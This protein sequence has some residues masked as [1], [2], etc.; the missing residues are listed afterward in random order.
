MKKESF[1]LGDEDISMPIESNYTIRLIGNNEYKYYTDFV[2]TSSD[3]TV[4]K[5][6]DTDKRVVFDIGY[7]VGK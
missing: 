1:H 7:Y 3:E 4:A 5:V 6:D 2:F